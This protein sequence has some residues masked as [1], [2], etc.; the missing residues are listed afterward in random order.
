MQPPSW[1]LSQ[2]LTKCR[3]MNRTATVPQ[4]ILSRDPQRI[5]FLVFPSFSMMALASATEPLRAVNRLAGRELYNWQLLS[6]QGGQIS[7]S[8][9]FYVDTVAIDQRPELDRLFVV[10]SLDIEELR[11]KRVNHFLQRLARM[12]TAI[13]ALSTGSFVLARAGLLDGY[14]CTLHWES[15]S[16]FSEEFPDIRVCREIYVLDRNRWTCAGGI[17]AIDLMLTQIVVDFGVKIAGDVAEQFLHSRIRGPEEHQRMEIRLRYGIN[18]KRIVE[19]I[20]QMEQA[21]EDPLDISEI[22]QVANLSLRHMERLWHQHFGM[23]PQQFY[24]QIR[25]KEAQ[26]LLKEST[27]T[28]SS[29]ALRCGFV[30]SSHMGSTYRKR[31]GRSPGAER[32]KT[33]KA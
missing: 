24:V 1:A 12:G 19:A 2:N 27:E 7:S 3:P 14:R 33:D 13:G 6:T 17:A 31:F 9:G 28:I 20:S 29:I 21:L 15:L 18:D 10:A 11:D 26:R 22:A 16:Q 25:L 8:S 4:A 23:T 30:S 32:R 5:G